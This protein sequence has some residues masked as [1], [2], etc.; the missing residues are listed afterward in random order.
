MSGSAEEKYALITGAST[1]IGHATCQWL[2]L[3]GWKILAGVRR[4]QDARRL[5]S[6]SPAITAI[7]LDVTDQAA[8]SAAAMRVQQLAPQGLA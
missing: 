1:G 3:R 2:A 8:V 4:D 6:L 7:T 5:E